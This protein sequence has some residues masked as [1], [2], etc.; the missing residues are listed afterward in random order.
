MRRVFI[1]TGAWLAVQ[2][3][4]DVHHARAASL[5]RTLAARK[6]GLVT[7]NFVLAETYTLLLR[8]FGHA[9]AMTFRRRAPG[10]TQVISVDRLLEGKAL[11]LLG[12]FADQRFSFV[13]GTSFAAMRQERLRFALSFDTDFRT[14]GFLRLGIDAPVPG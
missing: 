6:V 11:E 13:D 8:R 12:R 4:G 14:A 7:T 2:A 1:D 9:Q 5:F 3:Q 10:V